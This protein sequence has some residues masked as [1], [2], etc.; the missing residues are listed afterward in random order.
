MNDMPKVDPIP[1][2]LD[3][4]NKGKNMTEEKQAPE[5]EREEPEMSIEDMMAKL[6]ELVAARDKATEAVSAFKKAIQR[7]VGRL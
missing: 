5:P 3:R 1:D 4:R 7:R 6:N 2:Y